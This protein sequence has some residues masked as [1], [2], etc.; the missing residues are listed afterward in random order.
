ME[1]AMPDEAVEKH[2]LLNV[3]ESKHGVS[4]ERKQKH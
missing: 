2:V 3:Y 1:W 4:D